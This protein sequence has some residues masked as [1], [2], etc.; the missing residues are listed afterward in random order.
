MKFIVSIAIF[1][2]LLFAELKHE[3]ATVDFLKRGIKIID[4]RTPGEWKHEGVV[5]GSHL[6]M[7]FDQRGRYDVNK[8]FIELS[9]VVKKDEQFAIICRTGS[10]TN[11]V[12]N[13]LGNKLGM[14]VINLK[15]GIMNM[16][17]EGYK[18]VP[19]N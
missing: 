4:I 7:F 10:R 19:M 8:F 13:F 3:M 6:I 14:R 9:Q 2:S 17:K 5:E 12:G 11:I 1:S 18:P 15:G 16:V